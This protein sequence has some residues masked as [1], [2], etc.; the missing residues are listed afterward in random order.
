MLILSMILVVGAYYIQPSRHSLI[1][2]TRAIA[3]YRLDS[4]PFEQKGPYGMSMSP[5]LFA[6]PVTRQPELHKPFD[7]IAKVSNQDESINGDKEA[8]GSDKHNSIKDM[9]MASTICKIFFYI[10]VAALIFSIG[11]QT[12]KYNEGGTYVRLPTNNSN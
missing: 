6:K 12:R 5:V 9:L 1:I 2:T 11:Y 8:K 4:F 3:P 10:V 7:E